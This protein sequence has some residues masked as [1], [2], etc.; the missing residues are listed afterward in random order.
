MASW[1]YRNLGERDAAEEAFERW[2]TT[3]R[4][5]NSPN[6]ASDASDQAS[7]H[8]WMGRFE[9]A[10]EAAAP[11]MDGRLTAEKHPQETLAAMLPAFLETGRWDGAREAH[12]RAYRLHRGDLHSGPYI[13]EHL[14]FCALT[15][16]ET[17]G[18][19]I[20][21]RHQHWYDEPTD[22]L[23][24]LRL[25]TK[26]VLLLQ[27]LANLG[28]TVHQRSFGS[29][30][31]GPVL[32]EELRDQLEQRARLLAAQF[33][34]RSANQY[35]SEQLETTISAQPYV[36]KLHLSSVDRFAATKTN[37]PEFPTAASVEI[38]TAAAQAADLRWDKLR[39]ADHLDAPATL[40][41][42]LTAV[43]HWQRTKDRAGRAVAELRLGETYHHQGN[44]LDAAEAL[45]MARYDFE[46]VEQLDTPDVRQTYELLAECQAELGEHVDAARTLESMA[47]SMRTEGR[48]AAVAP[49]LDKAGRALRKGHEPADA[50]TKFAEAAELYEA[51]G[52][53][54]DAIGSLRSQ[55]DALAEANHFLESYEVAVESER[56]AAA[57]PT[58]SK[59]AWLVASTTFDI[60]YALWQLDLNAESIVIFD[61]AR[62]CTKKEAGRPVPGGRHG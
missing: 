54:V 36:Q 39:A 51:S 3:E 23:T 35:H 11:V 30:P 25:A 53:S 37:Q 4:D 1:V 49:W 38:E 24:E 43:Q 27:R 22:P 40:E 7:H 55:V 8:L 9:E 6:P 59:R 20:L 44:W 41:I 61:Q 58:G 15:G 18:L 56:R 47:D 26:S 33:D 62:D 45:E 48:P 12:L 2:M 50:A 14:R 16:N 46:K 57:L 5:R 31:S 17:R 29:R 32:V 60:G 42:A 19:E 52:S 34:A 21:Q 13:A 28:I 10:L